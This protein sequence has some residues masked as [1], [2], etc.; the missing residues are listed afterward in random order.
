MGQ[1]EMLASLRHRIAVGLS[2]G[3]RGTLPILP[4]VRLAVRWLHVHE[5]SL[6]RT[7]ALLAF[8]MGRSMQAHNPSSNATPV[9][10]FATDF[11]C[12]SIL[13]MG[14]ILVNGNSPMPNQSS[15][16]RASSKGRF[17]RSSPFV[18]LTRET[19]RN[20]FGMAGTYDYDGSTR[21][22]SSR[23]NVVGFH[24]ANGTMWTGGS[25]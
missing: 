7:D 1:N 14:H 2:T 22:R 8:R 10:I 20:F 23:I 16:R 25:T 24:E 13:T 6:S 3:I 11:A 17:D 18:D 5:V 9:T 12:I 21:T 15:I 19:G 4:S